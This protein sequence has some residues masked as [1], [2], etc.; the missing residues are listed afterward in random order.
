MGKKKVNNKAAK[1]RAAAEVLVMSEADMAARDELEERRGLQPRRQEGDSEPDSDGHNSDLDLDFG[2]AEEAEELSPE[3]LARRADEARAKAAATYE[4]YFSMEPAPVFEKEKS[5]TVAEL[6]ETANPNDVKQAASRPMKAKD[7]DLTAERGPTPKELEQQELQAARNGETEEARA[8]LARLE[9][10]R[11]ERERAQ[12]RREY[13]AK[14][15]EEL[16][17]KAA[18]RAALLEKKTK[19]G[20]P[21]KKGGKKKR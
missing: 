9:E 12:A 17:I 11:L 7:L 15:K 4:D 2:A 14:K 10:I 16:R 3:E 21:K 13:E 5:L 18:E 8:D 6:I 19:G 20:G 1:V